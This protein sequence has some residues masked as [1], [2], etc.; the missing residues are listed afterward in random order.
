MWFEKS[1]KRSR[2]SDFEDSRRST[3]STN[4]ISKCDKILEKVE[5][6]KIDVSEIR[7]EIINIKFSLESLAFKY[8]NISPLKSR[9]SENNP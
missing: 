2:Q 7:I 8:L 1:G 6:T 5:A 3:E 9:I 4:N